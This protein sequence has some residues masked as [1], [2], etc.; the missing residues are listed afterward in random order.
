MSKDHKPGSASTDRI[1]EAIRSALVRGHRLLAPEE[2]DHRPTEEEFLL[3]A[4]VIGRALHQGLLGQ[5]VLEGC[6]DLAVI[7]GKLHFAANPKAQKLGLEDVMKEGGPVL[8]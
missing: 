8:Q 2:E 1:M 5:L 4:D 3:A 7:N 6:L